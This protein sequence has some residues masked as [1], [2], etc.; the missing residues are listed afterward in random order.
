MKIPYKYILRSIEESPSINEVSDKLF[1]L[2]HEHQIEN[3]I[4][5]LEITPNRGDCLSLNGILNDLNIFYNVNKNDNVYDGV[6]EEFKFD[7]ENL[8]P[9]FCQKISFLKLEITKEVSEYKGKLNDYFNDFQ[10]T[11]NNFFTDVSNYLM[12]EMGQPTHCYDGDKIKGRIVLKRINHEL[13]FETLLGKTLKL[14]EN[15][16]V[17]FIDKDPINLAGIMGGM[18]TSC[19]RDTTSILLECAYFSP[20]EIMGKSLKYG[21]NSDAAHRFER[22]VDPQSHDKVIRRFIQIVKEHAD[23]ESIMLFSDEYNECKPINI[24]LDHNKINKIIGTNISKSEYINFLDRLGFRINNN[25][26]TVPSFRNDISS[27]NDL[28]EEIARVIGY[29]NIA[30]KKIKITKSKKENDS[31]ENKI[32]A[33]L[34][35]NGFYEVINFPFVENKDKDSI[36]IDN[37]LDKTRMYLRT[38]ISKSLLENLLYNERRQKDSIKLFEISDI[39]TLSKEKISVTKNISILASGRV[40]KNYQEFSKKINIKYMEKLFK[41][42]L[43]SFKFN[44]KNISRELLNS[45]SK[46]EI[47]YLEMDIEELQKQN[48]SFNEKFTPPEKFIKYQEIS[49]FPSS[50]RDISYLIKD[51]SKIGLLQDTVFEFKNSILKEIFIFDYYLNKKTNEIKMGFRFIFQSHESTLTVEEVDNVLNDI[52]SKTL[53]I[54]SI[55]IPG[56]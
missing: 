2:G 26:I 49:E 20:D 3:D 39:Y 14:T 48:C 6:I 27:Q 9:E 35:N 53:K 7:F 56:I 22:G 46:S 44:F 31:I 25:F 16:N 4:F 33:F 15:N 51:S 52:M 24:P 17:F 42:F 28:A 34:V 54:G 36:L 29:N 43:P 32:K 50:I 21:I 18:N 19:S 37:P 45:K 41:D 1:Q 40:G 13:N 55:E 8:S 5:D 12:F 30:V 38:D 47:V 10:L 11:K 23:I